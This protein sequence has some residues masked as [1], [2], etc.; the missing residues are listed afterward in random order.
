MRTTSEP[1]SLQRVYCG[2]GPCVSFTVDGKWTGSYNA[3]VVTTSTQ[4]AFTVTF[5]HSHSFIHWW[6][7]LTH[8]HSD[9]TAS[10]VFFF[11]AQYL[12]QGYFKMQAA[13]GCV[14]I[15]I[16]IIMLLLLLSVVFLL[17]FC[18]LLLFTIGIYF[19]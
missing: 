4:S 8:I 16:L 7:S 10:D 14:Y 11:G 18:L 12:V 5:T 9:D 13:G 6:Q 19:S 17:L 2:P 1:L 3:I 15:I